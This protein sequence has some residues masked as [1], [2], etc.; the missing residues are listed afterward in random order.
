[1]LVIEAQEFRQLYDLIPDALGKLD[2]LF[3]LEIDIF[4]TNAAMIIY[5]IYNLIFSFNEIRH[6][7]WWETKLM[8]QSSGQELGFFHFFTWSSYFKLIYMQRRRFNFLKKREFKVFST[9][10]I[11]INSLIMDYF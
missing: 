7:P 2:D 10:S 9:P 6:C 4:N 8:A 1:M 5:R 11:S 3:L